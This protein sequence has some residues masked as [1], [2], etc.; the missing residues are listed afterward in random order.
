VTRREPFRWLTGAGQCF[1]AILRAHRQVTPWS[2]GAFIIADFAAEPSIVFLEDLVGGRIAEDAPTVAE[3][4]LHF[5]TLRSEALPKTAS[6]ELIAKVAE[7]RW[8]R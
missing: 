3:A 2:G 6:R 5:S 1:P 4:S 8:K 7:E